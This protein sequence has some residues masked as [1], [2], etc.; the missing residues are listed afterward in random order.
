MADPRILQPKQGGT[1]S[2]TA[3]TTGQIP[4]SVSGENYTPTELDTSIVSGLQ[5]ALDTKVPYTGNRNRFVVGVTDFILSVTQ[6]GFPAWSG[7]GFGTTVGTIS[8]LAG[9]VNHPGIVN[10]IS[11]VAANSGYYFFTTITGFLLA[12][13]ETTE[14]IFKTRD[15]TANT[16]VRMGFSDV[17]GLV[18]TPTDGVYINING[19]TL[20]G[21]TVSN[22]VSSTTG[23]AYTLLDETWYR[24]KIILNSDA[25]RVDFYL[26]NEAGIELWTDF[27]TT[28]IP[29]T[30]GRQTGHGI[31][32]YFAGTTATGLISID[33]MNLYI[34]RNLTR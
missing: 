15:I 2:G 22:S 19:E 7:S 29:T 9:E 10:L 16:Y 24:L 3:P 4:Y 14:I 20:D 21:R 5:T 23:T 28:N 26:Y 17:A 32:A 25:T 8:P 13:G 30:T 12:G 6:G 31:T 18:T 11:S 33:Y 1:G 27:L 34:D